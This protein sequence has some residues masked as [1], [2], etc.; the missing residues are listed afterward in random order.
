MNERRVSQRSLQAGSSISKEPL[1]QSRVIEAQIVLLS[2]SCNQ[3]QQIESFRSGFP[4]LQWRRHITSPIV[5]P[6]PAM[7]S[8]SGNFFIEPFLDHLSDE[9]MPQVADCGC[10]QLFSIGEIEQ[11]RRR[12]IFFSS[13]S[14]PLAASRSRSASP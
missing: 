6:E 12:V 3:S 7:G 1:Y 10:R 14:S 13:A 5:T 9:N 8:V 4:I 2:K 11:R